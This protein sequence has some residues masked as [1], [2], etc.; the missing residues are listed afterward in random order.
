[1]HTYCL[2]TLDTP[3]EHE[4]HSHTQ[5]HHIVYTVLLPCS[6]ELLSGYQVL[7]HSMVEMKTTTNVVHLTNGKNGIE[8]I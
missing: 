2:Y 3:K 1:M 7:L 8:H 4:P 5:R 6:N